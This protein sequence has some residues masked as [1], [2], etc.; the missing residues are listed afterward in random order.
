MH[1]GLAPP[2]PTSDTDL[3]ALP[4]LAIIPPANLWLPPASPPLADTQSPSPFHH[5]TRSVQPANE[6]TGCDSVC[7]RRRV[8]RSAVHPRLLLLSCLLAPGPRS[9]TRASVSMT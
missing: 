1:R 6:V 2:H 3:P 8:L 4:V 7:W 5:E 9:R